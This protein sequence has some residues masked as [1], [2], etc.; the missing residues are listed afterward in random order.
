MS[1]QPKET[2]EVAIARMVTTL[3]LISQTTTEANIKDMA[4][5]ALSG[6]LVFKQSDLS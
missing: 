3:S 4:Y 6:Y 2:I 5:K 1:D